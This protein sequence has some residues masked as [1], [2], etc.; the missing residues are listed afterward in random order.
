MFLFLFRGHLRLAERFRA[1]TAICSEQRITSPKTWLSDVSRLSQADTEDEAR[2]IAS[3]HDAFGGDWRD[4]HFA[5]QLA[6][7]FDLAHVGGLR[8]QSQEGLRLG[9]P[10]PGAANT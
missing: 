7:L 5:R 3:M 9:G 6:P 1:S 8:V 10:A 2:Q 4:P